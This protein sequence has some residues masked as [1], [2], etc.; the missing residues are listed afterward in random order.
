MV[1]VIRSDGPEIEIWQI[2]S[3]ISGKHMK[4]SSDRR[5]IA[6]FSE[7]WVAESN[8]N[9][10]ILTGNSEIAA[11]VHA[12]LKHSEKNWY[13]STSHQNIHT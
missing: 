9:V 4:T 13:M 1:K 5:I 11:S 6:L 10:R 8:G 7:I 12:Q 3:V 2:F